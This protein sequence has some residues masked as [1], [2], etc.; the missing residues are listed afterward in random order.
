[1]A[2]EHKIR[3]SG[4]RKY[5]STSSIF[6]KNCRYNR[7][8]FFSSSFSFFKYSVNV[9]FSPKEKVYCTSPSTLSSAGP[10]I[11]STAV[12]FKSSVPYPPCRS[13]VRTCNFRSRR[14]DIISICM[15]SS[16]LFH[17]F[18]VPQ[19]FTARPV[20]YLHFITVFLL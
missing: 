16:L 11:P 5:S 10:T 17:P 14:S 8:S 9:S 3:F 4:T 6:S 7:K 2:S 19:P 12:L 13:S 18:C 20:F 15:L 1:M